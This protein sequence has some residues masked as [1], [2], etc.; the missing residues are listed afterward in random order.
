[1]SKADLGDKRPRLKLPGTGKPIITRR[2]DAAGLGARDL[3]LTMLND[4]FDHRRSFDDA[5]AR[6]FASA[7]GLALEPRDRGLARLI[8]ATVLRRKGVIEAVLGEFMER[9]L[10]PKYEDV[11]RIML[12][13]AAQ[14]LYLETPPHAA[15][16][17]AVTQARRRQATQHFSKLVNAIMRRTA[18]EGAAIREQ[19]DDFDLNFPNW[20]QSALVEAY[21]K[22]A[23]KRIAM[24]SLHEAPLDLTIKDCRIADGLDVSEQ[25]AARLGGIRL[26][27]STVRLPLGGRVTERDGYSEGAWWVQDAAAALPARL[28]GRDLAGQEVA[29]LCAAPGGKTAQLAA[30]GARVTAI[31]IS[32]MRLE[33]VVENLQ[34]LG[35]SAEVIE[36]DVAQ[37]QPGR[38]FD[39]VLLDA[40]CS[41][42]GTIRRHPDVL[43]LKEQKDIAGLIRIQKGLLD[44]AAVLVRPGGILVYCTCSL[45]PAEGEHR[46]QGFLAKHPEFARKP[47]TAADDGI[48]PDWITPEGD[49][50]TLPCFTP[51]SDPENRGMDGFFAA[52]LIRN[53]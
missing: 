18:M 36:A 45:L 48:E 19:L 43:H 8:A 13:A 29:D 44:R 51:P 35:L 5:M 50:R 21:G 17:V 40:P 12:V 46:I 38:T 1:M 49:L 16:S 9:P 2:S 37:W 11:K 28:F 20:L 14:I 10:A 42:T 22:D 53:A 52:R 4:V 3:A 24:A 41:A 47:I 7:Q 6:A 23:A 39:A 33:R 32:K 30:L 25:W 15:V 26:A 27:T 34:R 31:D